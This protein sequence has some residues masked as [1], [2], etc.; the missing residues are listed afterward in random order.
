MLAVGPGGVVS[1][2]CS[3]DPE[4]CPCSHFQVSYY[5]I[6]S[7]GTIEHQNRVQREEIRV[8]NHF[9]ELHPASGPS[10]NDVAFER[11]SVYDLVRSTGRNEGIYYC[12]LYLQR[13]YILSH[14]I[15][16]VSTV[17][18]NRQ[19]NVQSNYYNIKFVSD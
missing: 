14:R 6:E 2:L 18:Q 1:F 3:M 9:R 13:E 11:S 19:I 15:C 12:F 10:T 4:Q 8:N 5:S 7:T 16:H 17:A